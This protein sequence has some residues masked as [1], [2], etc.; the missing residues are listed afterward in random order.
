LQPGNIFH[1]DFQHSRS[2][3]FNVCV[4]STIQPAFISSSASCAGVAAVTGVVAKDEKNLAALE[5]VVA[6]DPPIM[7]NIYLLR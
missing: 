7:L 6:R 3:Y 1:P 4:C 2:A 5:R